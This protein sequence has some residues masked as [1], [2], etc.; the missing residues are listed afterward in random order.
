MLPVQPAQSSSAG[1]C[2]AKYRLPAPRLLS[3]LYLLLLEDLLSRPQ[4]NLLR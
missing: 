2:S 1:R 4:Y 3:R